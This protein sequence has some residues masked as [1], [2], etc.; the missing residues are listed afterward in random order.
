LPKE[1]EAH[2]AEAR[3]RQ[4]EEDAERQRQQDGFAD[5]GRARELHGRLES[6]ALTRQ[7][8]WPDGPPSPR[9]EFVR[10]ADAWI[11]AV[12][13]AR[14][15]GWITDVSELHH[16][17]RSDGAPWARELYRCAWNSDGRGLVEL[18]E[19]ANEDPKGIGT[20]LVQDSL[21]TLSIMLRLRRKPTGEHRSR[22]EYLR[23]EFPRWR[24]LERDLYFLELH[25]SEGLRSAAIRDRCRQEHPAW[26]APANAASDPKTWGN[27][28]KARLVVETA[29]K[30]TKRRLKGLKVSRYRR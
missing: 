10:Y 9:Q 22:L 29:L 24:W 21:S 14:K 4:A 25:E 8:I 5:I 30:K 26:I 18:F 7:E 27:N 3:S 28:H 12:Q 23:E 16:D 19:K 13:F 2:L 15:R 6:W 17:D 11:D 20:R 1:L